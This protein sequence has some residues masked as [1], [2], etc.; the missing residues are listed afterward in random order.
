VT[1][2][3]K[4]FIAIAIVATGLGVAI[5]LGEPTVFEQ[6]SSSVGPNSPPLAASTTSPAEPA[7]IGAWAANSVRLVPETVAAGA[8]IATP[9]LLQA[10]P[11]ESR[12]AP[13]STPAGGI[14]FDVNM[15]RSM[16]LAES[17]SMDSRNDGVPRA[18]L[19]VEAPRPMGNEPRSPATIRRTPSA[20]VEERAVAKDDSAYKAQANWQAPEFM[21]AGFASESSPMSATSAVY[22]VPSNASLDR[23][24]A[25]APWIADDEDKGPRMHVVVDGDSLAKL[26]GRY[27]DDPRRGAEIY[28]LNRELLANPE[29][30]P[31]GTQL[32]IPDR[33]A[34][35]SWDKQS[36]RVG[37]PNG[38]AVRQAAS[39][40]LVP[41][42]PIA[43][44]EA[45]IP[46]AQL[47]R[48]MAVE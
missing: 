18:S 45:I 15:T 6:V 23:P 28:E 19:R 25:P 36:R 10:P 40:S 17:S 38:E 14:A 42:R 26:A 20:G 44:G 27:L 1:A 5:L 24:V 43:I 29:L 41:V 13:I 11:L 47:A 32:K 33:E 16:S 39:G 48:P 2:F 37:Y 9:G 3:S 8:P 31:I 46:Q 21:P 4:L 22:D 34:H 30:L 12:L 35:T 7:A